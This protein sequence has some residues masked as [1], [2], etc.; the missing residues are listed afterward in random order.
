NAYRQTL[1]YAYDDDQ[2]IALGTAD[3][4]SGAAA[5]PNMGYQSSPAA[6]FLMTVFN[7]RLGWW[8][9]NPRRHWKWRQSSPDNGL[10]Y[11]ISELLGLTHDSS[12]FVNTSDGGHFE[13]LGL[14]ELVR[15]RC[16][17]IICADA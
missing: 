2:G 5:N 13:N 12:A 8:M 3:A 7:A 11:L 10:L 16:R 1:Q 17:Y 6:G 15:R 9:G 14:Y 4:I